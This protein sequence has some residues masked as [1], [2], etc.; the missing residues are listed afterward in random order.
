MKVAGDATGGCRVLIIHRYLWPENLSL[1]PAM[2]RDIAENHRAA[3]D[4]VTIAT[5]RASDPNAQHERELWAADNGIE[6]VEID[7]PPDRGLPTLR[8]IA[9]IA[10]FSMFALGQAARRD[11]DAVS[12]ASYPFLVAPSLVVLA[13]KA[14]R[15]RSLFY[16]QDIISQRMAAVEGSK[17]VV[18]FAARQIDN[19]LARSAD[20]VVTL[21]ADMKTTLGDRDNTLVLQNFIIDTPVAAIGPSDQE[22]IRPVQFVYAGNLGAAQNLPVLLDAASIAARE[23][24]LE[25]VLIGDGSEMS[26]LRSQVGSLDPSPVQFRGL[27]SREQASREVAQADVGVVAAEPGLFQSA[28]PSKTLS[29]L[30]QG[31]PV[32]TMC[33]ADTSI[34]LELSAERIGLQGSPT[35]KQALANA[36]VAICDEVQSGTYDRATIATWAAG[37]YGRSTYFDAYN[38]HVRPAWLDVPC[39]SVTGVSP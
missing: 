17:R 23:R 30:S 28:W 26:S 22:K 36:M 1:Y 12:I 29:Y 16:V 18:G 19:L 14:R 13:A 38:R 34:A 35:D 11:Y 21:S 2:L 32:L 25:V 31:L 20:V 3:G 5:A 9:A 8:R 39:V 27:V 15:R 37:R 4:D 7:L 33:E 24:D 10:R 6:L